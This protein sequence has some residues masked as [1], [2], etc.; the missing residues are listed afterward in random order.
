MS[1]NGCDACDEANERVVGV[2]GAVEDRTLKEHPARRGKTLSAYVLEELERLAKQPP[3][4]EVHRSQRRGA[5]PALIE[6]PQPSD[7]FE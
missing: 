6:R 1:R 3:L 7:I 2:R 5:L 4:D